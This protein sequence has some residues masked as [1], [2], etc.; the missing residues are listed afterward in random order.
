MYLFIFA[1]EKKASVNCILLLREPNKIINLNFLKN[2][3]TRSMNISIILQKI[4]GLLI[5]LRRSY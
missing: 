1:I 5:L 4:R 3:K 2:L